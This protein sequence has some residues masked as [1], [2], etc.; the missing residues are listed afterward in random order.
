MELVDISHA[1]DR[2]EVS[3]VGRLVVSDTVDARR[4]LDAALQHGRT[5]LLNGAGVTG[6]DTA[7]LQLLAAFCTAARARGLGPRWTQT[8]AALRDGATALG[9]SMLLALHDTDNVRR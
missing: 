8:S 6:V 5:I 7:G 3:L 9:L 2:T 1:D 4:R